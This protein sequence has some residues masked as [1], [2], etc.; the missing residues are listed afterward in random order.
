M[1]NWS[2]FSK[3]VGMFFV[4]AGVERGCKGTCFDLLARQVEKLSDTDKTDEPLIA[5]AMCAVWVME[6]L[7]HH[8]F[9]ASTWITLINAIHG[10][11]S[12]AAYDACGIYHGHDTAGKPK[13]MVDL[14]K[15]MYALL[16]TLLS[17]YDTLWQTT[18]SGFVKQQLEHRYNLSL[19]H[20]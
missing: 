9:D 1:A 3:S 19:I 11:V 2:D 6:T 15:E 17:V 20:I 14:K 10:L 16:T 4:D 13:M 8:A 5:L 18:D 7:A 12:C